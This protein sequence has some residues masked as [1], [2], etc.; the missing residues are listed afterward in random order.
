MRRSPLFFIVVFYSGLLFGQRI[1][2]RN[3]LRKIEKIPQLSRAFVGISISDLDSEKSLASL[4]EDR[5]MTPASNIKLLTFLGTIQT[6][7]KI[8]ALEYFQENDSIIHFRSTGY[9]LL[10]HPFYPDNHL[11]KFL[12]ISDI[13]LD[14]LCMPISANI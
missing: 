4:N 9:P 6:F 8:P 14:S 7:S 2:E 13:D 1:S 12:T 3:L 10:L 5:Y 11:F